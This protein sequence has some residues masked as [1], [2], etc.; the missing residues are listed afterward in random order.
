HAVDAASEA[1]TTGGPDLTTA[2]ALDSE[3]ADP[4]LET[5]IVLS[6]F[7]RARRGEPDAIAHYLGEL[8]NGLGVAVAVSARTLP[9]TGQTDL[10]HAHLIR[11]RLYIVC[12]SPY[13]I[14]PAI[15]A[16]PI[17]TS[18]RQLQLDSFRDAAVL[19]QVQGEI[20]P[21]WVLRVDLTPPDE[22]LRNLARWGDL[23]A[24]QRL[25]EHVIEQT[26]A[27]QAVRVIAEFKDKTI[28]LFCQASV[29]HGLT[30]QPVLQDVCPLLEELAPQ[31][32]QAAMIYWL[33]GDVD[34]TTELNPTVQTPLWVDWLELPAAHHPDLE[35][36]TRELAESGDLPAVTFLLDRLLNPNLE[37]QLATGGIRVSLHRKADLLHVMCDAPICPEQSAIAATV[38]RYVRQLR[39]PRIAGVRVY[40]RRAGQKRPFWSQGLDFIARPHAAQ[41]QTPEFTAAASRLNDLLTT[42]D[43]QAEV[44]ASEAESS[45]SHFWHDALSVVRWGLLQSRVFATAEPGQDSLRLNQP[46]L[47]WAPSQPSARSPWQ[48]VG[49]VAVWGVAGV[50]LAFQMDVLMGQLLR[51]STV[52]QVAYP[53]GLSPEEIEARLPRLNGV[54]LEPGFTEPLT[55]PGNPD[56]ATASLDDPAADE[57][58]QGFNDNGFTMQTVASPSAAEAIAAA[59]NSSQVDWDALSQTWDYPSFNNP[60]L[61]QKLKLYRHYLLEEGVPDI[62]IVG[63]SRALRGVDPAVLEQQ[64]DRLGYGGLRAFNLAINGATAEV[65]NWQ[66][67]H[68]LQPYELPRLIIWADGARAF[69]SGRPDATYT[70]I[71]ASDGYQQLAAQQLPSLTPPPETIGE[72]AD[73]ELAETVITTTAAT[74]EPPSLEDLVANV[75]EQ[76]SFVYPRRQELK[77]KLSVAFGAPLVGLLPVSTASQLN[78]LQ[79]GSIT[80]EQGNVLDTDGLADAPPG[81][82]EI[83]FNGFLPLSLRFNPATY[84]EK[85]SYVSGQYDS[86]YEGFRIEGNQAEALDSLM[87]FA[88]EQDLEVVFL[89]L[90]LTDEYLDPLR[91][92]YEQVFQDYMYRQM[93]EQQLIFR[94]LVQLWPEEVENFSDPSHLNRYGAYEV[95]IQLA[96]DPLIPWPLASSSN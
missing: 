23:P 93:L 64:L 29:T 11:Q 52:V 60:L 2:P 1:D 13:S 8:F 50:L 66:L 71:E 33:P 42:A 31:G 30:K 63:S 43:A 15:V 24:L 44:L 6:N 5:A 25:V 10:S 21:D 56:R 82:G 94:N 41:D 28:H 69:N 84:Y 85:Y 57:T 40:G 35:I 67:Q 75:L 19:S 58:F 95:S 87:T 38:T 68:L 76:H 39:L 80:D 32:I 51:Q 90:P 70:A 46:A 78:A 20:E 54:A 49:A 17:A 81:E 65:V 3:A 7:A 83:D 91:L 53:N 45:Q 96:E 36:G 55:A 34:F 74:A 62:L 12:E 88:T 77:Q 61:D 89:N 47:A 79:P 27:T 48:K 4:A 22:T 16:E 59:A 86:N 72:T 26:L 92:R 37:V 18:L 9:R 14:D 73:A